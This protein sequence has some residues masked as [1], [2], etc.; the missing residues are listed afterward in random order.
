LIKEATL[1]LKCDRRAYADDISIIARSRDA[2]VETF[3][4]LRRDAKK[5]GLIIN[6]GKTKYMRN[7]RK[8]IKRQDIVIDNMT[9]EHAS[10][11]KYLGSI[12]N[13]T[14]KTEEEIQSRIAAGNRAYHA[15]KKLLTNKLL[16]RNS[17]MSVYKTIIRPVVTYGS[18]TW[19]MNIAHEEKL[20]IFER[21]MLSS[22]YGPV[23]DS[24]NE[25]R[26][27]TNQEIEALMKEENIV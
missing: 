27:R 18:E 21:K 23:Q 6:Q 8:E 1:V 10:S 13:E 11:F 20:K 17:K 14:N 9:F 12:V 22:I 16:S 7:A 3:N 26:V 4:T 25:W 2:L 24:N 5:F 15:N 19:M